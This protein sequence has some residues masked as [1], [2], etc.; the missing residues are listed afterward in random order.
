MLG[1]IR[2]NVIFKK[3][4]KLI[5][6]YKKLKIIN[7]NKNIQKRIDIN[8]NDYKEFSEKFSSIELEIIP[9][10]NGLGKIIN[11][12]E[13]DKEFYHI[14]FND[15][16]EKEIKSIYLYKNDKVSKI[17]III[18][19][20]I[21]SFRFLFFD[22]KCIE[23]IK[24]KKFYRNNITNM[25]GMF[26]GCLSLKEIDFSNFN[27]ENVTD[28]NSMFVFCSSIKK[29]DLSSFNTKNVIDMGYMF[30]ECS[31]LKILN[32]NNFNASNVTNMSHIFKG[33]SS[34]ISIK[35]SNKLFNYF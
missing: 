2:S 29:L 21:K 11:I 24:F 25:Y 15:N 13:E 1:K 14:Y 23:S 5:T 17:N 27:T 19:Y 20:Q 18:D 4:M 30:G 16:K 9:M 32:L 12:K 34:I 28:M 10:E 6:C 35:I 31:S 7:Y 22:C 33:C 8:I 3:I 26:F